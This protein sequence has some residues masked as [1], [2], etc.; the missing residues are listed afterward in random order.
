MAFFLGALAGMAAFVLLFLL[1]SIIYI[2]TGG[3][4]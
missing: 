2:V 3:D 1:P 4:G